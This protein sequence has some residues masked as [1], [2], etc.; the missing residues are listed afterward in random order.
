MITKGGDTWPNTSE[1]N[2]KWKSKDQ[3]LLEVVEVAPV[4]NQRRRFILLACEPMTESIDP[5][6]KPCYCCASSQV[7]SFCGKS[8]YH[9]A[10]SA[11]SEW[12]L[13]QFHSNVGYTHV[14]PWLLHKSISASRVALVWVCEARSSARFDNA[15]LYSTWVWEGFVCDDDVDSMRCLLFEE[16]D[17]DGV[18]GCRGG[19]RRSQCSYAGVMACV[20]VDASYE[21]PETLVCELFHRAAKADHVWLDVRW[22]S[23][24]ISSKTVGKSKSYYLSA[25]CWRVCMGT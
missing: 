22:S 3:A 8:C 2:T 21:C 11:R 17:V 14:R 20:F 19:S 10:H 6:Q 13:L 16:V 5:V 25:N 9:W 24:H 23:L 7:P 1:T 15:C 18:A 12:A 4:Y